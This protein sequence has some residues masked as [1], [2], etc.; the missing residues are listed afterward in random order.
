MA[1]ASQLSVGEGEGAQLT[2]A[3]GPVHKPLHSSPLLL[4]IRQTT[5]YPAVFTLFIIS[6][7]I[8][9]VVLYPPPT[10][11][12]FPSHTTTPSEHIPILQLTYS[13]ISLISVCGAT[14]TSAEIRFSS[15]GQSQNRLQIR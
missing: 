12:Y 14:P 4:T 10:I 1:S 8:R 15:S 6:S 5:I 3:G 7:N 9:L 11:S 13:P 2:Q